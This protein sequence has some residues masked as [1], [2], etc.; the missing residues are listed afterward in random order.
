MNSNSIAQKEPLVYREFPGFEQTHVDSDI[1]YHIENLQIRGYSVIPA[2]ISSEKT[3]EISSELVHLYA[4]QEQHFG[5]ERL[6][7][8]NESEVHRGLL[9]EHQMFLEMA[10]APLIL[11]IVYKLIGPTAILNLQNASCASPGKKHYQSAWHRDF[12]KDFVPSKCLSMNAFWC[13]SEFTAKNGATWVLP[14]SHRLENFPSE[15]YIKENGIQ[16]EVPAGSIILW[17]SLLLH[18][19][20]FNETTEPRFGINH[21][22]T[23]PFLKQQIDFPEYLKDKIEKE[24]QLGQLLGFWSI[25][26]KSV[27]EFRVDPEKRTYRRGQG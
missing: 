8:L 11:E 23:R 27:E 12:A 3:K 16:L 18:Q 24:S 22:Y 4:K 21:M 5:K 20:G 10:A 6:E 2:A 15:R 9:A 26:P 17:D 13:I 19:A 1:E 25:P 7:Q 14:F